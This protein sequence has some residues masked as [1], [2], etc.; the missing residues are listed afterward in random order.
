MTKLSRLAVVFALT[1]AAM[2]ASL[3]AQARATGI[4]LDSEYLIFVIDT[5]GS[6]QRYEWDR[7][8]AHIS[9]TL[10]AH[11]HLRGL[12]VLND[13]GN[14][15]FLSY[16]GEWIA[17]TP[18][19]RASIIEEIRVWKSFSNSSPRRGILEAIERYADPDKTISLY[20]YSDDFSSGSSAIEALVR[21]ID[22]RNHDEAGAARM[23]IHAV[24]FPVYFDATGSMGTAGNYATL[25]RSITQRNGGSFV[26]LSS[27]SVP[28]DGPLTGREPMTGLRT[29]AERTLILVDASS[30]MAGPRWRRVVATVDE[31]TASLAAGAGYQVVAFNDEAR[32]L[33]GETGW[34]GSSD[35]PTRLRVI[36]ALA[37]FEPAGGMNLAVAFDAVGDFGPAPDDAYLLVER[38]PTAGPGPIETADDVER[39]AYQRLIRAREALPPAVPVNVVLFARD[40]EPM[41]APGYWQLALASGG[42]LLAPAEDWP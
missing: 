35:E 19:M 34:L 24:A 28:A 8:Q 36:E 22:S 3:V 30:G 23:K 10:E 20:V 11:P 4:P 16:S 21:E 39:A 12:Q 1:C 18:A 6:M 29:D 7:L 27:R 33:V 14:H 25:M 40:D 31:L 15:L 5:S 41:A 26:A 32:V 17:D 37:A 13:E 42:S 2:I 9:A 38:M